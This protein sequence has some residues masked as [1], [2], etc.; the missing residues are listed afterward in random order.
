MI[1]F[2]P[3]CTFPTAY[4]G[5]VQAPPIR[6]TMEIVWSCLSVI[7]LCTWSILHLNV[8][9]QHRPRGWRQKMR[10]ELAQLRKKLKWMVITLVAPELL[11]GFV[12]VAFISVRQSTK[13][14]Q[15]LANDDR[16]PWSKTH[17]WFANQGGFFIHFPP[18]LWDPP[19]TESATRSLQLGSDE[20]A[21]E[22]GSMEEQG[23]GFPNSRL[24]R[25]RQKKYDRRR[26]RA[27]RKYGSLPGKLCDNFH[28]YVQKEARHIE[29]EGDDAAADDHLRHISDT[30]VVNSQQLLYL[31]GEG[32]IKRLPK[33]EEEELQDRNKS[34]AIVKLLAITQV[35]WLATQLVTRA[36]RGLPVTTLEISAVAYVANSLVIY[37]LQWDSIKDLTVPVRLEASRPPN[38][39]QFVRIIE[40]KG[41]NILPHTVA[42]DPVIV[43]GTA[44]FW[45]TGDPGWYF[46]GVVGL[47][48]LLF[49]GIHLAAWGFAFPTLLE[50]KLWQASALVTVSTP[51]FDFLIMWLEI[52]YIESTWAGGT[53]SVG[54]TV[55]SIL[56]YAAARLF[57]LVESFRSLYFL[58]PTAYQT[59]WTKNAPHFG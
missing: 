31:R 56:V 47:G 21:I 53:I 30:W 2:T 41:K 57:T 59:T 58:P 43:N 45:H 27:I 54:I 24:L 52:G 28:K 33:L 7:L 1:T 12:F 26:A 3:N 29:Q 49:G 10:W 14:L 38:K 35:C 4:L 18:H 20:S 13:K 37:L 34:N 16:V 40:K 44:H 17:S 42:T 51:M 11:L 46:F 6:G 22:L 39:T 5:F 55:V 25:K 48:G 9:P 32:I 15:E 36:A 19:A 23:L 8:P 50:R